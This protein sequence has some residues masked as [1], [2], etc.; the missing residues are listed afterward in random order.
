MKKISTFFNWLAETSGLA[1]YIEAA[2]A[3][4]REVR[5]AQE[6]FQNQLQKTCDE[7]GLDAVEKK[8]PPTPVRIPGPFK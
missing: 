6:D 2:R 5:K 1:P 8:H 7:E 4:A 3:H